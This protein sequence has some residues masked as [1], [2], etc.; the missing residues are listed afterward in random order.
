M[1]RIIWLDI[2]TTGLDPAKDLILE[3]AWTVTS[4]DDPFTLKY[5]RHSHVVKRSQE[6]LWR[7]DTFV[8][9][10]HERS[11][12]LIDVESATLSEASVL[13]SLE[14]TIGD[15]MPMLAGSSVH[16]DRSF[17]PPRLSKKL[18]HRHLDISAI[19]IFC[20]F[21]GMERLPKAEAYR[22]LA[23]IDESIDHAM[24]CASWI[25]SMRLQLKHAEE[26][27]DRM[28]E[29]HDSLVKIRKDNELE[30]GRL[31]GMILR[32]QED[33]KERKRL[34]NKVVELEQYLRQARDENRELSSEILRFEQQIEEFRR[35]LNK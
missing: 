17:L 23:D 10:M 29:A 12:L 28:K 19:K 4:T 1:K 26:S 13:E 11:E 34:E 5:A 30:I 31:N 6:E 32:I 16:F 22:A 18:Y 35:V 33:Y 2:E 20:E 8:H 27:R 21:L 7:M 3:M 25:E 14:Q 24:R 9:N 15:D